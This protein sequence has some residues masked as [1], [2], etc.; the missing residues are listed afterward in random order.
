MTV[1]T[2]F[3]VWLFLNPLVGMGIAGLGTGPLAP[4]V[5]LIR[6]WAF[7]L[8]LAWLYFVARAAVVARAPAAAQ[9]F[10]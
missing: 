9:P 4:V 10:R 7:G 2:V 8:V 5:S 6:H 1:Q 3:G